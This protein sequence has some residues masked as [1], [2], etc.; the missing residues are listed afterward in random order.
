MHAAEDVLSGQR[1]DA[2]LYRRA[3]ELA[4][5]ES[6]PFGDAR[7]SAEYKQDLVRTILVRALEQAVERAG[8]A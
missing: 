8:V 5:E 2:E 7:G 4:A 3:G 6:E 1:P